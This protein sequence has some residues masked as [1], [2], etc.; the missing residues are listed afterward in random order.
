MDS[1]TLRSLSCTA[2]LTPESIH[3][4]KIFKPKINLCLRLL[5]LFV[6]SWFRTRNEFQAVV[7][8]IFVW[9]QHLY[10][11]STVHLL[12]VRQFFLHAHFFYTK[13]AKGQKLAHESFLLVLYYCA[14]LFLFNKPTNVVNLTAFFY[15]S[16]TIFSDSYLCLWPTSAAH[17]RL[18]LYVRHIRLFAH[19]Y[20]YI[21]IYIYTHTHTHT[22]THQ[23]ERL[24]E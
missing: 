16:D 22:H 17:S 7:H 15:V 5:E 21:Y 9:F 13:T 4:H 14:S 20:I 18:F 8:F 19:I 12:S 10:L 11:A 3:T 24:I 23:I 6:G 1:V 2:R